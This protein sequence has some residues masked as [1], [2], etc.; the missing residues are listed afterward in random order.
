MDGRTH[1]Y[2]PL[3]LM[4]GDNDKNLPL[5]RSM[6]ACFDSSAF[7]SD[8][9]SDVFTIIVFLISVWASNM[10]WKNT[11]KKVSEDLSALNRLKRDC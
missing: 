9:N 4:S 1:Y 10:Y 11:R 3:R 8:S 2:S 5:V 7:R 6:G